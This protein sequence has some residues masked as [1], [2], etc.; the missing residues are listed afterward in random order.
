MEYFDICVDV[1]YW[2]EIWVLIIISGL[3]FYFQSVRSELHVSCKEIESKNMWFHNRGKARYGN[4]EKSKLSTARI[5]IL[6]TKILLSLE[7]GVLC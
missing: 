1:K 6:P 4:D 3:E 2:T 7:Y 5:G